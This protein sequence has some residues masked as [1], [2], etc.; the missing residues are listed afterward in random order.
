MSPRFCLR[1]PVAFV[2]LNAEFQTARM[3]VSPFGEPLRTRLL[4]TVL[5]VIA[6]STDVIGFLGL[7]GLFTAH[8]TGN[9]VVLAAHAVTGGEARIAPMLSVPVFMGTLVAT[10]LLAG[11]LD[12]IGRASLRPLL[13]VQFLLLS[14][15]LLAGVAA[16][17]AVDTNAPN[18]VIAGMLGVAAMAV[19]AALVQISL[20]EAPPTTVL[21]TNI[22]RFVMD[23]GEVLLGGELDSVAK[24]SNRAKRTLPAIIGFVTGCA[25]GA[26]CEALLGLWSFALPTGLAML[27]FAMTVTDERRKIVGDLTARTLASA[28]LR[29]SR[30]PTRDAS[31][32]EFPSPDL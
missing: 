25:L 21:T 4:P 3:S 1:P 32:D 6:G 13:L 22:T 15:L 24:A 11:F 17:P 27:A 31:A 30:R 20:S 9:L 8:V 26:A 5:S 2:S 7:G 10:R 12:L 18:L 16:G 14:G 29:L 23:I 28:R 19:Q